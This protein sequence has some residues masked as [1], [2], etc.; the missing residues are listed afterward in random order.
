MPRER[1]RETEEVPSTFFFATLPVAML[2]ILQAST[3][4]S[5]RERRFVAGSFFS[6]RQSRISY[7]SLAHSA[8]RTGSLTGRSN[9]ETWM[10]SKFVQYSLFELLIHRSIRVPALAWGG[11]ET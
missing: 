4:Y 5:K 8:G 1:D 2:F 10:L 11:S 7:L 6:A 9:P 3:T